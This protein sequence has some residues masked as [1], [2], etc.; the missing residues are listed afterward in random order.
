M[1]PTPAATGNTELAEVVRHWHPEYR[2]IHD[3]CVPG[4]DRYQAVCRTDGA[5]VTGPDP[6]ALWDALLIDHATRRERF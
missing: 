3:T 4:P 6:G 1:M 5:P 2:D